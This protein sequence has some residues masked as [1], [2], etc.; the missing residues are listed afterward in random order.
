MLAWRTRHRTERE[1]EQEL[2]D[3]H[4]GGPGSSVCSRSEQRLAVVAVI[5]GF[6][7]VQRATPMTGARRAGTQARRDRD[8]LLEEDPELS[9]LLAA[10]R[11]GAPRRRRRRMLSRPSLLTSRVRRVHET[12]VPISALAFNAGWTTCSLSRAR[13]RGA[14]RR[15]HESGRDRDR[16]DGART[17]ASPRDGELSSTA[18]AARRRYRIPSRET[19][20]PLDGG[21]PGDAVLVDELAVAVR[22]GIGSS[23]DTRACK[24]VRRSDGSGSTAVYIVASRRETGWRSSRDMKRASSTPRA[25]VS[26]TGSSTG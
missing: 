6:A 16:T 21:P 18:A 15:G 23:G 3:R 2:E 14:R 1:V 19:S 5:A 17:A 8:R 11:L 24:P 22:N 7:L 26:S 20:C 25:V 4:R 10:S 12:V 9:L 13:W